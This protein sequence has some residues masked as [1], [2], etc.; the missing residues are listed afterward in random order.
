ME[1]EMG[2]WGIEIFE[3]DYALDW[4]ADLCEHDDP[5]EFFE[6][7]LDIDDCD[8]ELIEC[9]G[10]LGT[11][12]MIDGLL[13]GPKRNLPSEAKEWLQT[14]KSLAVKRLLKSAIRGLDAVLDDQ[15]EACE[16]W[17]ENEELYPKWRRSTFALRKRL[18][19]NLTNREIRKPK[20]G[21]Q[22]RT[23]DSAK[24]IVKGA[25]AKSSVPEFDRDSFFLPRKGSIADKKYVSWVYELSTPKGFAYIQQVAW[26]KK[27]GMLVR[28]IPGRS[29]K[30]VV[31]LSKLSLTEEVWYTYFEMDRLAR[32]KLVRRVAPLP[33]HMKWKDPPL[34]L[35]NTIAEDGAKLVTYAVER[36]VGSG[37]WLRVDR[38]TATDKEMNL[39][40]DGYSS[41]PRFLY[42]IV[43]EWTPRLSFERVLGK[44]L[45]F[46]VKFDKKWPD[47]D[48]RY[49]EYIK[50]NWGK[51]RD[52]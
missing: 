14:H 16:L 39:S 21:R 45:P 43:T 38:Y 36:P 23:A 48:D 13:N 47:F 50:S 5:K 25:T 1:N 42:Q 24:V 11:C 52:Q 10:V 15:S 22:P 33:V 27:E 8:L 32:R 49:E 51:N 4:L 9:S 20:N 6:E 29:K 30:A 41:G 37:N 34:F 2:S 31:D 44:K 46:Q 3:E 18:S 12:A 7:C 35:K 28:V 40:P 17:K 26:D 19:Q